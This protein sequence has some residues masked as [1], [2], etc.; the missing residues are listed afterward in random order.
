MIGIVN[1]MIKIS[2]YLYPAEVKFRVS[3][4]MFLLTVIIITSLRNLIQ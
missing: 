1:S 4:V 3:S 2:K